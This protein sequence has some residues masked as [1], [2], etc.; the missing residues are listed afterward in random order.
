MLVTAK[1]G[2]GTKV[3]RVTSRYCS[4][5]SAGAR[6]VGRLVQRG[7]VSKICVNKD[8]SIVSATYNCLRRLNLPYCYAERR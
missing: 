5:S 3:F 1:G 2:R 8:R 7:Q 6:T 4:M